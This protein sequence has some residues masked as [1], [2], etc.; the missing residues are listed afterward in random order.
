[1]ADSVDEQVQDETHEGESGTAAAE[2]VQSEGA[3]EASVDV[4]ALRAENERLRKQVAD[5]RDEAAKNRI[6]KR[7]VKQQVQTLEERL[8]ELERE[9]DEAKQAADRAR[10]GREF[11]LSDESLDFLQGDAEQMRASAEKLAGLLAASG[12]SRQRVDPSR[13]S[14]GSDPKAQVK[15]FDARETLRKHRRRN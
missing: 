2:G 10:I 4:E 11:G 3:D 8:A 9:R 12:Q 6:G 13:W 7:E 1:M 5:T 15:P 14:G